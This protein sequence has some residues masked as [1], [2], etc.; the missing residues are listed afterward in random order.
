MK[1]KLFTRTSFCLAALLLAGCSEAP[2]QAETPKEPPKPPE[3]VSGLTGLYEMYKPARNWAKDLETLKLTSAVL[4]DVKAKPGLAGAWQATFVSASQ[5]QARSFAYTIVE[6]SATQ[7]KG[8]TAGSSD[9]WAGP[10]PN[11]KPFPPSAIKIDS[12]KAY[13]VALEKA[14]DV[15]KKNADKP[16]TFVLEQTDRFPNPAWRV[17]WGESVS[18]STLSVFVD[19]TTGKFLRTVR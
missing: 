11:S 13:E 17:V 7:H 2:K 18:S 3:A 6:L 4:N 16:I 15:A 19:A 1:L 12:D 8:V 5:R 10:K 14:G 9:S